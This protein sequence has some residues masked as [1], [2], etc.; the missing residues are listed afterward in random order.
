MSTSITTPRAPECVE[1][2]LITIEQAAA[3]LGVTDRSIRNYISRGQLRA[4]RVGDRL[5]RV[6]ARDVDAMLR[7]IPAAGGDP[8]AAA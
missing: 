6:D 2:V 8:H 1:R 7:P 4:Y 5:V 3:Y